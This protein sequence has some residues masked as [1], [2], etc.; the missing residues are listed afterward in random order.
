[1][2]LAIF[3][4]FLKFA[5]GAVRSK[6]DLPATIDVVEFENAL[7]NYGVVLLHSHMEQCMRRS[8]DARLSRC[9]DPQALAFAIDK[10]KETTGRIGIEYLT[11]SLGRFSDGYKN[12]FKAHLKASGLG[13]S[14]DSVVNQRHTVAHEGLP[15]SLTLADLRLYYEHIRKVLGF[16]CDGLCL[17]SAEVEGISTLIVQ[18]IAPSPPGH[19]G[20]AGLSGACTTPRP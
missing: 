16:F 2:S 12:G 5:E 19:E 17:T 18:V 13:T 20:R 3:E 6:A 11:K 14:W 7:V 10:R 1:M 15:A 9:L 4:N 8:M